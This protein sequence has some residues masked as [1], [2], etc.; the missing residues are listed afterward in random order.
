LQIIDFSVKKK[1]ENSR[2]KKGMFIE[3]GDF[4]E[5]LVSIFY[6]ILRAKTFRNP[7][8]SYN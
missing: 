5:A 3:T 6:Y 8:T 4:S 2:L 1:R 7:G